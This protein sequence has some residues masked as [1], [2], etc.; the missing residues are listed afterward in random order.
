MKDVQD[1]EGETQY[2]LPRQRGNVSMPNLQAIRRTP[3]HETKARRG[4]SRVPGVRISRREGCR[5][6]EFLCIKDGISMVTLCGDI[7]QAR[8]LEEPTQQ[9][10]RPL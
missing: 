2:C 7:A 9:G 4:G 8:L 10:W 3:C 5:A 1:E 6:H